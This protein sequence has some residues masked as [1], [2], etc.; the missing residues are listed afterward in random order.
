MSAKDQANQTTNTSAEDLH[1]ENVEEKKSKKHKKKKKRKSV[2]DDDKEKLEP[3][4]AMDEEITISVK[5]Q[6][7]AK[8]TMSDE[9]KKKEDKRKDGNEKASSDT[10]S[11]G[12]R[13]VKF[14]ELNRARSWTASMR[15]LRTKEPQ[16][17]KVATPE[18][19][20]LLNK[21]TPIPIVKGKR[22]KAVD[23]F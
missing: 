12:K 23:Y 9:K 20:I 17:H 5:D 3:E 10:E 8:K 2:G 6:K 1:V 4:A 7:A 13:R 19:G 18:K 22:K 16:A 11:D 15:G 14:G 21:D